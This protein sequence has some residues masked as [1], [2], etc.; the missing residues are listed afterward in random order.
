[1]TT[2]SRFMSA[3]SSR[4]SSTTPTSPAFDDDELCN[5]NIEAAL[6]PQGLPPSD[7]DPIS[8]A[9]FKSLH[10]NAVGLLTRMQAAFRERVTALHDL[11]AERSAQRD[12][13][14]EAE[15]RAR[16]LKMQLEDMARKAQ[17]HE[18]AIQSLA[19][20]LAAER[21]ARAEERLAAEKRRSVAGTAPPS[22]G[23]S[24]V[25]EDLGVDEDRQRR[26]RRRR[27]HQRKSWKSGTSCDDSDEDDDDDEDES[28]E[29]ESVFSRCRSPALPP[30]A[31][32]RVPP[33]DSGSPAMAAMDGPGTPQ[34]RNFITSTSGGGGG[35]GGG[36]GASTSATPK[37][38]SGPQQMSAFQ[39]IF[40]G[41]SGDTGDGDSRAGG[42][43]NC[44]GQDASVAWD[45]VSLL[46]DENKHLK[47]RVGELEGAV[48]GA[49]DA[50]NGIGL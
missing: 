18:R 44:R 21:R 34:V 38:K 25:S 20:E 3:I 41:I 16:H 8:P 13:L 17:E 43:A 37:R 6:F 24:M 36:S 12:E 26:R 19:E 15:T 45:T 27:S 40:R 49:L 30:P 48:E 7:R 39:R 47:R 29:S 10:M 23:A 31:G 5:L 11:Q 46:R 4:F 2:A 32:H 1:M 33:S 35:S 42:C 9:A 22:E 28:A 14:E 50:V